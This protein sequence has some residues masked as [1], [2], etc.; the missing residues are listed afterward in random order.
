MSD[1]VGV[2]KEE[3]L[4]TVTIN[5]PPVNA[6]NSR[7]MEALEKAFDDLAADESVRAVVL[8]GAGEKAFVAGAD[9]G[10]FTTLSSANGEQLSRRGQLIFQKIEDLP[11]PVI[12]AVDGFA[13]GGG[14]ELAL[15]CDIR[16]LSE[17]ARV[18]PVSY[19]HL[20]VY[21]RQVLVYPL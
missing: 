16:V 20:D 15:A 10:E 5:H 11:A 13:L 21:K 14:L 2:V 4:A 9:I 18:G 19:T 1:L 12:A 17:G 6:L 3:G 7:V 8:T